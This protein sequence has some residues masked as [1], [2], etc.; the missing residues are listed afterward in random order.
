M[1]KSLIVSGVFLAI[2]FAS[3]AGF[4][5][6]G[7]PML[8]PQFTQNNLCNS[9]DS[10][11]ASL[12][13]LEAYFRSYYNAFRMGG[14]YWL[15]QRTAY[16]YGDACNARVDAEYLRNYAC[17]DGRPYN[18]SDMCMMTYCPQEEED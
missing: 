16:S 11:I 17:P 13:A 3:P 5:E 6:K 15:C 12:Q 4:A 9:L 7:E 2:L 18:S 8:V 1:M 14:D 10:K